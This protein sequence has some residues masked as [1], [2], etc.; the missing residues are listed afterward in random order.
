V[1]DSLGGRGGVPGVNVG[2]IAQVDVGVFVEVGG[3]VEA[4][5]GGIAVAVSAGNVIVDVGDG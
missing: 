1:K 3:M 2:V 4:G 5:D